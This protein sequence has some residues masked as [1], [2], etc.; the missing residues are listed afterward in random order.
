[1]MYAFKPEVSYPWSVR[2]GDRGNA[3][4]VLQLN[5][6][7]AI[8][9]DFGPL[10]KQAVEAWQSRYELE[11]DGIAGPATSESIVT[12]CARLASRHYRLPA[13]LLRSIAFNESTFNIY[14]A[15]RHQQD[16]GWD[17]GAFMRSS[18]YRP[19]SPA[20]VASAFNVSE[21]AAWSAHNLQA[22]HERFGAPADSQ[23]MRDLAPGH[24]RRF[25]WMLA[26]LAHNWPGNWDTGYGGAVGICN[27]GRAS[28][29]DDADAAWV[30]EATRGTLRTPRQ[31]CMSYIAKATTFV[32]WRTK[33]GTNR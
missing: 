14:A 9:G 17:V 28:T 26:V 1:M 29:N 15:G 23:Y 22:T 7:I 16:E 30:I 2:Y 24:P 27:H 18:G 11:V 21:S 12:E 31:W 20:W 13:G 32:R 5:L 3:V 25:L 4:A 33:K 10:T 19:G 6:A 8:D